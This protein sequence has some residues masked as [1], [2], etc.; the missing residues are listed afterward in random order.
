MT[1]ILSPENSKGCVR[2]TNHYNNG[3]KRTFELEMFTSGKGEK[4]LMRYIKP[5]SVKGQTFLMLNNGDD[6]WTYFPRTRRV[7]KL[8]SHAKKQKVQG[9]DFSF[10]DFSSED[11]WKNDYISENT[12]T[13][14]K[15]GYKCWV[16]KAKAGAGADVD[17]P[18]IILYLRQDNY[19]PVQM[20]Y[21]DDTGRVEKTMT[22]FNIETIDGYPTA[23]VVKMENH[24][25]GT[26]TVMETLDISFNWIPPKGFFSERSLK[27]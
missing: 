21:W 17:Y 9:G 27:K 8:A 4:T 19:Y 24:L 6:I 23:K 20:D 18:T 14:V 16:L 1:A 10:E 22:L 2:Q 5:T 3:K 25:S 11:T 15:N 13:E 26:K 7:R 12:G